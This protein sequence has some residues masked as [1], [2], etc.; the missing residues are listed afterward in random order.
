[1]IAS[2]ILIQEQIKSSIDIGTARLK[3]VQIRLQGPQGSQSLG[4]WTA[5]GIEIVSEN[6]VL[7]A[8]IRKEREAFENKRVRKVVVGNNES[9]KVKIVQRNPPKAR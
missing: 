4:Q 9:I 6:K 5:N 1:L 8:Q 2:E 3:P 7:N